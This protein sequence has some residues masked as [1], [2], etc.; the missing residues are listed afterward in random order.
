MVFSGTVVFCEDK[1]PLRCTCVEPFSFQ[2][3]Q[4]LE[5]LIPELKGLLEEVILYHRVKNQTEFC[6]LKCNQPLRFSV[7]SQAIK[8]LNRMPTLTKE[9]LISEVIEILFYISWIR[10]ELDQIVFC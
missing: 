3:K 7:E 2:C 9:F 1:S 8:N 10:H 5:L 6:L 4:P